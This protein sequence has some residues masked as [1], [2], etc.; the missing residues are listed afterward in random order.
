MS[1]P[2]CEL[3]G[4]YQRQIARRLD[5]GTLAM[6]EDNALLL[7]HMAGQIRTVT[8]ATL[9]L[10]DQEAVPTMLCDLLG[11]F[12]EGLLEELSRKLVP[13]IGEPAQPPA[14]PAYPPTDP[15]SSNGRRNARQAS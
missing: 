1:C 6:S 15:L 8:R 5:T 3:F 13:S 10:V 14:Y 7:L 11:G 2:F 4:S 12:A 9:L